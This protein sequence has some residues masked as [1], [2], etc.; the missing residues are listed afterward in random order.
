MT[1]QFTKCYEPLQKLRVR[2]WSYNYN[3]HNNYPL[4]THN[5]II[6]A[7]IGG[8]RGTEKCKFYEICEIL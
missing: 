8:E 1:E 2:L 6:D 5:I 7:R 4:C 3:C